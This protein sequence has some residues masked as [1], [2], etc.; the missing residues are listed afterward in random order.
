MTSQRT[1]LRCA[2]QISFSRSLVAARAGQ[3]DYR[4]VRTAVRGL[5]ASNRGVRGYGNWSAV[6][7]VE[8]GKWSAI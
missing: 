2:R 6:D 8:S 3:F 5:H 7:G 4:S 1:A